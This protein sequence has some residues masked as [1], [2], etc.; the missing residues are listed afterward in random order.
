MC[1]VCELKS[2]KRYMNLYSIWIDQSEWWRTAHWI[3]SNSSCS[4][5]AVLQQFSVNQSRPEEITMREDQI[6]NITLVGDDGFGMFTFRLCRSILCVAFVDMFPLWFKLHVFN[7][8]ETILILWLWVHLIYIA[9][10]F[11]YQTFSFLRKSEQGIYTICNTYK[12]QPRSMQT[13]SSKYS[14]QWFV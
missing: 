10:K 14:F 7:F 2:N 12:L 11:D 13:A 9:N 1:C 3:E 4:D 8:L 6:G 5:I